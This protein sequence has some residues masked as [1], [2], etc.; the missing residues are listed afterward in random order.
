MKYNP[1][2]EPILQELRDI[3]GDKY[4]TADQEKLEI[5]KTDEEGN[6]IYFSYPEAVVFPATTEEVAAIVKLANTHL[7]PITPRSAG[8]GLSCG[9]IP[10]HHGIVV[11]LERMNQIIEMNADD[12]YCI[13]QPGVRTVDLQNAAKAKGLLYAGDPCSAESCQIGGNLATNAGGNK[14]VK[15]GT[16]RHQI[17]SLT[18]VTPLGDIVK[19]GARLEKCSTGYCLEQLISGS[20]GTLGIITE[21][22]LKL[23]V[24]PPY[25]FDVVAIFDDPAK[26]LSLPRKVLKA[27]IEPTSIEYMDNRAINISGDFIKCDL[28]HA[29]SGGVY[30]IITVETYDPDELDKKMEQLS[31]LCDDCGAVDVLMADDR[32]WEARKMFADACRELCLTWASSDYVVPL[33]QIIHVTRKLPEI[34]EKHHIDGG[35]VAHIG[36]G[37]IHVNILN[38][39]NQGPQEWFET[40]HAYDD[41]IFSL[42]YSLGG[43]MSGEHGIGYKKKDAFNKF[44]PEGELK[45]M[46]LLKKAWDPNNIM[47]PSKII[48]IED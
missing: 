20:E 10:V 47:N 40:L 2:T 9:A 42:V 46:K 6:P 29:K 48:D 44:T 22:T 11:E 26:A 5:Y 45:L 35:I 24:L 7:I 4:V 32:I 23:K 16:T 19:V 30:D 13:V 12:L 37:N 27:G 34:M 18:V 39:Q 31:D 15:Y 17:Y 25:S 36:D 43:K 14:A 28:P 38:T 41:D 3:V 21:A 1:I 8:T 33:D